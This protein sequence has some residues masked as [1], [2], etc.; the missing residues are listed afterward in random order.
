MNG[1]SAVFRLLPKAK[2]QT[3]F[4]KDFASAVSG[5][6]LVGFVYLK[7]VEIV[8]PKDANDL[9]ARI[10]YCCEVIS[11]LMKVALHLFWILRNG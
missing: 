1:S 5:V 9:R 7:V 2:F 11:C 4:T 3:R 10:E 8:E 6:L